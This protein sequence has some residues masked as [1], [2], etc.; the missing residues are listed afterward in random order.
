M[1]MIER[2]ARAL[3]DID[4]KKEPEREHLWLDGKDFYKASARAAIEAMR[5]PTEYMLN[6]GSC[7][8]DPE[9]RYAGDIS[10]GIKGEGDIAGE[11]FK[12]MIDA[13]LSEKPV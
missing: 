4:Y 3:F 2:V 13:A 12:A 1:S 7:H 8:E 11:V 10:L 9:E 5:E 6:V